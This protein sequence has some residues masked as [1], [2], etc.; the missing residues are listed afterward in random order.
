MGCDGELST[1]GT[2]NYIK[3]LVD[4]YNMQQSLG[5]D[6]HPHPRGKALKSFLNTRLEN[7]TKHK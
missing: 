2:Q 7:A 6:A 3:A 1:E 4:L 5:L